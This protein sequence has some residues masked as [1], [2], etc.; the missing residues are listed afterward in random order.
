ML[1]QPTA[2]LQIGGEGVFFPEALVSRAD[3]RRSS[4]ED[5][6]TV[7]SDYEGA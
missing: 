1:C 4:V 7:A 6:V 5:L 3:L 2:V